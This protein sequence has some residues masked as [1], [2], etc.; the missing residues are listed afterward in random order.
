VIDLRTLSPWDKD[1]VLA[2]VRKTGRLLV[3]HEDT[4]TAGFAAE[5]LA[6]V[7]S[8]AFEALD[9]PVVRVTTPDI[10]I[11]YNIRAMNAVIPTVDVL[12][13]QIEALLS[14]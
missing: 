11:P 10:P 3:A 9:A 14:F 13:T 4:R 7:T 5:I 1:A 12:R 8:E 6:C 2:S